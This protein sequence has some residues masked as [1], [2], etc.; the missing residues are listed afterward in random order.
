[1]FFHNLSI[2]KGLMIIKE[3]EHL[4]KTYNIQVLDRDLPDY[5]SLGNDIRWFGEKSNE[6][7]P[8]DL[9]A[10]K[11]LVIGD[12]DA[13]VPICLDYRLDEENPIVVW[14]NGQLLWE[15]IANSYSEFINN[16]NLL[17]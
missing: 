10:R 12:L 7:F 3:T 2:A 11:A 8:G 17:A 16:L 15:K 4:V 13:D 5:K 9:D 1:Y 6:F 14:L